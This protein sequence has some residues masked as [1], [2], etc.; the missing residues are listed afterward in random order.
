MSLV[1]D[2]LPMTGR[3]ERK[4]PNTLPFSSGRSPFLGVSPEA[5]CR[6]ILSG[7]VRFPVE[8]FASVTDEACELTRDLLVHDPAKRPDLDR[9]LAHPWFNMVRFTATEGLIFIKIIL[10]VHII[11]THSIIL[12]LNIILSTHKII[13][14]VN[15][16]FSTTG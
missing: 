7:E 1:I 13:L 3:R 15:N 9:V 12:H 4:V 2:H 6:N 8:H 14:L 11:S 10:Y 16:S 5:T